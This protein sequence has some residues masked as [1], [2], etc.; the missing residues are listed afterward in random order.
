MTQQL[1]KEMKMYNGKVFGFK[2]SDYALENGYLD[3]YTLSK[4][5]GGA[6]LNITY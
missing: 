4:I 6:V 3:Y 5:V 1:E 2:V